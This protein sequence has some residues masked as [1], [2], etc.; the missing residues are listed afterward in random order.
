M[1]VSVDTGA[2]IEEFGKDLPRL[3]GGRV[4]FS[5]AR[6]LPVLVCFVECEGRLLLLKRSGKVRSY[7]GKWCAVAGIIDQAKP[8]EDLVLG[9]LARELG[10]GVSDV[11]AIAA[12]EPYEFADP[13]LGRSFRIHPVL[14]RLSGKPRI[15]IDWEHTDFEWI[16][17]EQLDQYDTVPMLEE[18]MRR[19]IR[20]ALA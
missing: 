5:S 4:D 9:E 18:S 3:P 14:A 17:P 20:A 1:K 7:Q 8:L 12:G 15:E 6:R 19:A 16:T 2:L 10:L 11:A 13:L